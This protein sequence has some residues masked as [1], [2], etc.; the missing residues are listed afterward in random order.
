MRKIRIVILAAV[1][2]VAAG[3]AILAVSRFS[4]NRFV[5]AAPAGADD[6]LRGGLGK[7]A[8][9]QALSDSEN[10]RASVAFQ[11]NLLKA[12]AKDGENA[13]L[14]P[15]SVGIALTMAANGAGGET[16]NAFENAMG[17][18]LENM[19]A[20]YSA[21]QERFNNSAKPTELNLANAVFFDKSRVDVSQ[22]F[23]KSCGGY[24]AAGLYGMDF[25]KQSA[26]DSINGWADKNS[27]GKIPQIID[28]I[29]PDTLMFLANS[30]YFNGLW[31]TAFDK[32]NTYSG[33]FSAP[34]GAVQAEYM[35]NS[36]LECR[37]YLGD[38]VDMAILPYKGDEYS[39]LA[40]MPSGDLYDWLQGFTADDYFGLIGKTYEKEYSIGLPKFEANF[41]YDLT[42]PLENIGLAAAFDQASADFSKLGTTQNIGNIYISDVK[43]KTYLKVD[44]EGTTAAAVTIIGLDKA[45]IVDEIDF[46][47]PFFYAIIENGTGLPMFMGIMNDPTAQ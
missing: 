13:F 11:L 2:V 30:V 17:M 3:A 10:L 36:E 26:V 34:S 29:S 42:E 24:F 8:D 21:A 37:C 25:S 5:M 43:H 39:F 1:F 9:G 16:L 28:S 38:N 22:D 46:H 6:L 40:I 14:S 35:Y 12:S 44:E 47:S 20:F 19:N 41:S 45:S 23:I 4:A 7:A 32:K 18:S 33:A 31:E 27:K 15:L